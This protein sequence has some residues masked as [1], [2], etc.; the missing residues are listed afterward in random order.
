MLSNIIKLKRI[1]ILPATALLIIAS[2]GCSGD[3]TEEANR[4]AYLKI[5][6]EAIS[7]YIFLHPLKS[8]RAGIVSADSSLFI[9]SMDE[10]SRAAVRIDRISNGFSSL[11]TEGLSE[12]EID[13]SRLIINFLHEERLALENIRY[14]TKPVIYC[15]AAREALWGIPSRNMDPYRG[16]FENYLGRVRKIP[17]MLSGARDMIDKPSTM[18][19]EISIDIIDEL[20]EE[21]RQLRELVLTRYGGGDGKLD[22]VFGE[23][24]RFR[25]FIS[26]TLSARAKGSIIL[27]REN[28]AG[29]FKYGEDISVDSDYLV[30]RAGEKMKVLRQNLQGFA[31][32]MKAVNAEEPEDPVIDFSVETL[33]GLAEK[34]AGGGKVFGI[35]DRIPDIIRQHPSPYPRENP[36]LSIPFGE[37]ELI[38]WIPP[39]LGN[40][41]SA[42]IAASGSLMEPGGE[43]F[44]ESAVTFDLARAAVLAGCCSS[45]SD[46]LK[47][48]LGSSTYKFG[49]LERGI[50]N[51]LKEHQE[52]GFH[53]RKRYLDW[54]LLNLARMIAV[55]KLHEGKFTVKAAV[56]F[57]AES[58][59]ATE[60]EAMT[61]IKQAYVSP[62][63]AYPGIADI[64]LSDIVSKLAKTGDEK[65]QRLNTDD[66]LRDNKLLP[67]PQIEKK[68]F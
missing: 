3:E 66:L 52:G 36:L 12:E 65:L 23:I 37:R 7:L 30:S 53:L 43:R 68:Y 58:V 26:D 6:E 39:C 51:F 62:S 29:I 11:T 40:P 59:G 46:T 21:M 42:R 15:W 35:K 67:L 55:F 32:R 57:F 25:K 64:I 13:N 41:H 45:S 33:S 61:Y 22:R 28:L 5:K 19:I 56:D 4:A 16:E 60:Q 18:H 17:E 49:R 27:G 10:I 34:I 1:L 47:T 31:G 8:S 48:L 63:V 14:F 50:E 54:Q 44:R 9:F 20:A 38:E 2:A 24:M